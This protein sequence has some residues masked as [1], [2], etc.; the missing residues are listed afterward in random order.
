M[1]APGDKAAIVC[2]T[3]GNVFAGVYDSEN[4]LIPVGG[5][6]CHVCGEQ[7]FEEA[8]VRDTGA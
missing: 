4:E 8:R 7:E 2:L 3:C 5:T 1:S 6:G